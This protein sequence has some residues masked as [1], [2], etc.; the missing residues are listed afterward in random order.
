MAE[1]EEAVLMLSSTYQRLFS[2]AEK[3][4]DRT[5]KATARITGRGGAAIG[6]FYREMRLKGG[7]AAQPLQEPPPDQN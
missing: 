2:S 7:N 5:G 3:L 1:R 6:S 4:K